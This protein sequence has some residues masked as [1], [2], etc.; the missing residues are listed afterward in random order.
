MIFLKI[1]VFFVLFCFLRD[2]SQT[3]F[4]TL[5]LFQSFLRPITNPFLFVHLITYSL[6]FYVSLILNMKILIPFEY[7]K[8]Y[9]SASEILMTKLLSCVRPTPAQRGRG[10]SCP[11]APP[12]LYLVHGQNGEVGPGRLP[13]PRRLQRPLDLREV[14]FRNKRFCGRG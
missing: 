2:H 11:Q 5:L 14:L 3:A 6:S 4:N 9:S 10:Y 13:R 1:S 12:R 7:S 8:F